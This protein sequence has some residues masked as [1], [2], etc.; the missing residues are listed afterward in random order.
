VGQ[1][2]LI[3]GQISSRVGKVHLTAR[4]NNEPYEAVIP[5]NESKASFHPGITTLWARQRV[6]DLMDHWRESNE[7]NRT[8]IRQNLITHAIQYHLVTRFTSLVRSNK[9]SSTPMDNPILL[10]CCEPQP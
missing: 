10:P 7:V 4:A 2:L 8:E 5:V 3:Y 9:Q 1:P 6:E